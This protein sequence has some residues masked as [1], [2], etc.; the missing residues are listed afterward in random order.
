MAT[1]ENKDPEVPNTYP[2]RKS[3]GS[4]VVTLDKETLANSDLDIGDEITF[5]VPDDDDRNL[6]LVDVR[7]RFRPVG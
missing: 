2:I 1:A 7:D 4:I 5:E 3:G 6:Q